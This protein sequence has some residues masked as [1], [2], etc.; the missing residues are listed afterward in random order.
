MLRGNQFRR[1]GVAASVEEIRRQ[2]ALL[3]EILSRLF[4]GRMSVRTLSGPIEIAR[5]SGAAARTLDPFVLFWFMAVISLQLG[6]LNLLPIPVLDGGHIAVLAFEG[7]TR[8]E[9]SLQVK[10][11]IMKVGAVM[12]VTLMLVVLSFDILKIV[13]A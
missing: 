4:T 3:G 1:R 10:E 13:S 9:L 11:R 7:I 6:L 5:Y 8:H 12:L 2:T